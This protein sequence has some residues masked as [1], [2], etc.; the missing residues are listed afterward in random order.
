VTVVGSASDSNGLD[1]GFRAREGGFGGKDAISVSSSSVSDGMV[2]SFCFLQSACSVPNT[3][4][5]VTLFARDT[6]A[7]AVTRCSWKVC[8]SATK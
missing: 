3:P 8:E 7:A 4:H 6:L 1:G 5:V 2:G